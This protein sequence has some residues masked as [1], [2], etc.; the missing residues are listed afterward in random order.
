MIDKTLQHQE[1]MI[2]LFNVYSEMLSQS[3]KNIF[4]DYY[5]DDLTII[6][7]SEIYN[8]SRTAVY[9]KINKIC[10]YLQKC[11]NNLQIIQKLGKIS[12]GEEK[13]ITLEYFSANKNEQLVELVDENDQTIGQAEKLY[14]HENNLLHRAISVFL[15]NEQNQLLMQQRSKDKYHGANLFANTCCSHPMLGEDVKVAA[16]RRLKDELGISFE[17][18]TSKYTVMYN[19]QMEKGLTEH[20]YDHIF[21]G[22]TNGEV[23]MEL[24]PDEVQAVKWIDVEQI[25]NELKSGNY[26]LQYAPWFIEIFPD[27]YNQ[28]KIQNTK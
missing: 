16:I 4:A 3:E 1:Y 24:N 7:I 25:S 2:D 28:H 11:E 12:I 26:S 13:E 18:F 15:V 27:F 6:E 23:E 9:K 22:Y 17:N 14:A 20:E 10:K 5:M 21:V 8:I 19:V